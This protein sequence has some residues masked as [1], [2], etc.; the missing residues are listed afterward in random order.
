MLLVFYLKSIYD[1]VYIELIVKV[2]AYGRFFKIIAIWKYEN[3]HIVKKIT[4]LE[5]F[6]IFFSKSNKN[7]RENWYF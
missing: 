1:C 6:G 7:I 4:I 2:W 5:N 3:D